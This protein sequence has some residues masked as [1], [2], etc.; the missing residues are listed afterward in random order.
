[1]HTVLLVHHKHIFPV[2]FL[3][4]RH[5][6]NH[7]RV[8]LLHH[9]PHRPH[10]AIAQQIV[11]IGK[12]RTHRNRPRARIKLSAQ[13]HYTTLRTKHITVR[14]H[15]L[16]AT[17]SVAFR[18]QA[19]VQIVRFRN[20][21][22][23]HHLSVVRQTSEQISIVH[24]T[25]HFERNTSQNARKRSLDERQ[26]FALHRQLIVRL[27]A[28]QFCRG[29]TLR[30][31][32][33]HLVVRQFRHIFQVNPRLFRLRLSFGNFLVHAHG[34]NAKERLSRLHILSLAHVDRLQQT[35]LLRTNLHVA[36]RV[37]VGCIVFGQINAVHQRS[38]GGV[39]SFHLLFCLFLAGRHREETSA[40]CGEQK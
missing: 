39:S 11:G 12:L 33:H 13:V 3:K 18:M 37:D 32:R 1:M 23:H 30:I 34:S 16:Q 24:Q 26:T 9:Q 21:E 40:E 7:H 20:V 19:I 17:L 35:L 14:Q 28:P 10:L 38:S 6:R 36:Q 2:L 29:H 5:L 15:Q 31:D 22:I 4:H 8:A 27:R 25:P